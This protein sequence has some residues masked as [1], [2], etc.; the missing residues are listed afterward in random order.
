[1]NISNDVR[2]FPFMPQM[3]NH[4]PHALQSGDRSPCKDPTNT[5]TQE[6]ANQAD[7]SS[8]LHVPRTPLSNITNSVVNQDVEKPKSGK[9]WYARM[10]DEKRAEYNQK[11]RMAR[12]H[13]KVAYVISINPKEVSQTHASS[14][15]DVPRTPLSNIANS[16]TTGSF[17][18]FTCCN[19][20]ILTTISIFY[21]TLL[22]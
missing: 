11:W 1:M 22:Y 17:F 20:N 6:T 3:R 12:A 13:K 21:A 16:N 5:P 10:S 15:P 8:S 2:C 7:S 14:S 4:C 18:I 19:F 9:N